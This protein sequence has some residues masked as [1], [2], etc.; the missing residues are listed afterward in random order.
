MTLRPA[1]PDHGVVF[2]VGPEQV[3]IPVRPESL[4]NGHYATTI[5]AEGVQ[6]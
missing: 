3:R 6:I 2:V 1:A 4:I 5:G